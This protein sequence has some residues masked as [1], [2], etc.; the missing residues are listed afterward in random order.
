[1]HE[2]RDERHEHVETTP[3]HSTEGEYVEEV[4]YDPY[5][6]R[7][8]IIHKVTQ[9][10]Y[11]MFGMIEVLLALRFVLRLFGANPAAPF[12]A[13]VYGVTAPFLAPFVGLFDIPQFNGSVVEIHSL[14]AIAVYAL[15]SWALVKLVWILFGETRHG[16]SSSKRVDT[17]VRRED[18]ENVSN[19]HTDSIKKTVI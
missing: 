12:G 10:I 15:I 9:W 14:V 16:H 1:M 13:F 2:R 8:L 18:R 6:E 5:A 19:V 4:N 11:L 7:R 17:Y 3:R